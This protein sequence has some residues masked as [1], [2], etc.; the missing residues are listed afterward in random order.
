MPVIT[1]LAE[2]GRREGRYVVQVDGSPAATVSVEAIARLGL[3][4]GLALDEPALARLQ[5]E[6]A[7]LAAY[8][9]AL[10]LLAARDRSSTELRRRLVQ[11]GIESG[12]AE[13]AV[14][15]LVE[16]GVVD[17]ARYARAL[18]RARALGAGASRRRI[19]QELSRR[20]VDRT[21]AD[22]AVNEVWSEEEV[23]Q[24]EAAERLARKRLGT[25][26]KLDPQTQRRRLYAYLARR[27]YDA[28]EIRH[29]MEAAMGEE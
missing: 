10:G 4:V 16:Q 28:D 1:G 13:A 17:D 15:R 5:E 12:P 6:D 22:E 26:G 8:D 7:V 20:G 29:A 9:R 21:V 3:A 24:R 14:A 27:G 11:K 19:A 18:T 25:M 23:D 2:S